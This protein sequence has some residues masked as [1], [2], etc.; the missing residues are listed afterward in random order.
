MPWVV[1]RIS[2]QSFRCQWETEQH[3]RCGPVQPLQLTV[4]LEFSDSWKRTR[5]LNIYFGILEWTQGPTRGL[6]NIDSGL[7]VS[8]VN[9]SAS[10]SKPA[11]WALRHGT[12]PA[13]VI[14]SNVTSQNTTI[15][16]RICSFKIWL[17]ELAVRNSYKSMALKTHSWPPNL[18]SSKRNIRQGFGKKGKDNSPSRQRCSHH[19]KQFTLP[20]HITSTTASLS[21]SSSSD[22]IIQKQ[23]SRRSTSIS[24]FLSYLSIR[25]SNSLL[26]DKFN[27]FAMSL[28]TRWI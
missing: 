26:T 16:C 9:W 23:S 13:F 28:P 2:L 7:F 1:G 5:E 3:S 8:S 21:L 14:C 10:S 20:S 19:N 6:L 15:A 22:E 18:V 12:H 11:S 27:L 4:T 17:G 24:A 25:Q